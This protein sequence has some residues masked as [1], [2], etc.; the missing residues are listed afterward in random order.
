M[1]ARGKPQAGEGT[2]FFKDFPAARCTPH[3]L[4]HRGFLKCVCS[5]VR[6]G[7]GR[8]SPLYLYILGGISFSLRD[9]GNYLGGEMENPD[10]PELGIYIPKGE[11]TP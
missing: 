9:K 6:A 4:H 8:I 2:I 10:S 7:A 5:R 11:G 3:T 1:E